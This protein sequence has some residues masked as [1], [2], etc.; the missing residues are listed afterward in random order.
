MADEERRF[1]IFRAGSRN[2]FDQDNYDAIIMAARSVIARSGHKPHIPAN[3]EFWSGVIA[4]DHNLPIAVVDSDLDMPKSLAIQVRALRH[5]TAM[6]D[7]PSITA[8][9]HAYPQHIRYEP[10]R[11]NYLAFDA[12]AAGASETIRHMLRRHHLY[13]SDLAAEV[14]HDVDPARNQMRLGA[15]ANMRASRR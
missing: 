14:L 3:I 6:P 9:M 5:A 7:W 13:A 12:E 10:D 11:P 4:K 8:L 1:F 15:L 2:K